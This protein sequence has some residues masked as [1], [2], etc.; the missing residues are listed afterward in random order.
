VVGAGALV[1]A[2]R[3]WAAALGPG[4][5]ARV[6]LAATA[7][8]VAAL[9]LRVLPMLDARV[10]WRPAPR[11]RAMTS[12]PT[13]ALPVAL[14]RDRDH[15]L[16]ELAAVV[17]FVERTTRPDEPIVAFP[18]LAMVPFLADRRTPVPDDY[19]FSG[20]PD[21]AAEA[22]MV[23]A[24]EE[25][26][27]PLVVAL[28]DRLGYFSHA[29]PYYF[30]LRDY[31][32]R[33]YTLVR[34]FGRYDVLVRRERASGRTRLVG[35]AL[36]TTFARGHHR[37]VVRLA[38]RI[39]TAGGSADLH[40]LTPELGDVDRWCRRAAVAAVSAVAER[41]GF[42][43]ATA[44]AAPGR[45]AFLLLVRDFGEFGDE[46]TLPWLLD[47][48]MTSGTRVRREAA[49]AINYVLARRLTARFTLTAAATG[50][51]W[52]FPPGL[53]TDRLAAMMTAPS[54]RYAVGV[55]GAVAMAQ[56]GR[57]DRIPTLERLATDMRRE[58]WIRMMT[59]ASLIHLGEGVEIE[60]L[61]E[62]LNHGTLPEQ[63]VPS[64]I[65]DPAIV[66]STEAA[67]IV[68]ARLAAGT[69]VERETA[70]WMVPYLADPE[71]AAD[72]LRAATDDPDP[73]V[74]QAARWAATAERAGIRHARR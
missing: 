62:T 23:A 67:A 64:M 59:T 2:E 51:L 47:T 70:A 31:V 13:S 54:H 19:F 43:A 52:T 5:L 48:Y 35:G 37:R 56:A 10:D 18:A 50:P 14:E 33:R 15:D 42:P 26:R 39:V 21:H 7:P 3:R 65:L 72:V 41:E 73:A 22:G 29:P 44:A 74:R 28:N 36:S 16:R 30:I 40:R 46:H 63:Y 11:L 71:A 4:T 17:R 12:L 61:F 20:R 32:Q 53:A 24:I 60:S 55:M 1:L 68:R 34:R 57:R 6:R 27:T 38:R 66:P 25:T 49:T 9:V 69:S 58:N 45:R 8:L